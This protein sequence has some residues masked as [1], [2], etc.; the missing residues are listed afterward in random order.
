MIE[1]SQPVHNFTTKANVKFIYFSIIISEPLSSS[2]VS[3]NLIVKET[4][5][6]YCN[7]RIK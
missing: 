3:N 5:T 1:H 4:G 6:V 2:L 7:Q